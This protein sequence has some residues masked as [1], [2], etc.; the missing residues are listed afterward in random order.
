MI[1]NFCILLGENKGFTEEDGHHTTYYG[2]EVYNGLYVKTSSN[3]LD[4]YG[5][6]PSPTNRYVYPDPTAGHLVW[7]PT[8]LYQK[9]SC[10][11]CVSVFNVCDM[12]ICTLIAILPKINKIFKQTYFFHQLFRD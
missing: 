8:K 4:N 1:I 9:S 11:I 5:Y 2:G 10:F 6:L 3:P 12:Q 7:V